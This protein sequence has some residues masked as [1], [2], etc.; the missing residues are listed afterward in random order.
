MPDDPVAKTLHLQYRG[1][2][3]NPWS[4][5]QSQ[6]MKSPHAACP[7]KKKKKV[8]GL[9]EEQAWSTVALELPG[10]LE[11]EPGAVCGGGGDMKGPPEEGV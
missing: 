10:P 7:K 6:G 9:Q 4:E 5:G 11:W 8:W 3:F 1:H 2:R